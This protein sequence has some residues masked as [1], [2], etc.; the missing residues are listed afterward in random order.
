MTETAAKEGCLNRHLWL[1]TDRGDED[2]RRIIDGVGFNGVPHY[3][4]QT[5]GDRRFTRNGQNLIFVTADARAAWITFRPTEGKAERQDKLQAWECALFRNEGPHLSSRL[6]REA[7]LLTF[8]IWGPPPRD[9]L[10]TFVR[11]DRVRSTNPGCC[12]L[13]AGWE[14]DGVSSKGYLRFR[15]PV[16]VPPAL[17]LWS[18]K[19]ARGGKLRRELEEAGV[20]LTEAA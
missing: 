10:I 13:K 8:A 4:R 20:R 16:V 1:I 5:P 18:W 14:R 19:G 17:S 9:G 15:A 7:A 6:I 2:V 3:S 12:Y 11:A